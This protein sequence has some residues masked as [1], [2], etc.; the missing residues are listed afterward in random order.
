MVVAQIV[1]VECLVVCHEG[2]HGKRKR[3]QEIILYIV[4]KLDLAA[5]VCGSVLGVAR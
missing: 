5:S 1:A 3:K 2:T 4:V